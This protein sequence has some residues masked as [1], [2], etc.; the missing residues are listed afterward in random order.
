MPDLTTS[1]AEQTIYAALITLPE[2]P[3]LYRRV[4]WLLKLTPIT[5]IM[6]INN[7]QKSDTL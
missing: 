2:S 5:G 1:L 6:V 4:S 3:R 7:G